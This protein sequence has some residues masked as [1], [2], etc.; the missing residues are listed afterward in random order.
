MTPMMK[1]VDDYLRLRRSLGH[2]LLK[3]ETHLRDF[4]SFMEKH[5]QEHITTAAV[6]RWATQPKGVQPSHWAARLRDVRIFAAHLAATDDPS[7]EIPPSDLLPYRPERKQ[8]HIYTEEEIQNLLAATDRLYTTTGLRSMTYVTLLGLLVVTG[9]RVSEALGLNRD[10]VDWEEAVLT[11]SSTKFNKTRLVPVHP[12]TLNAL[13]R[14]GRERDSTFRH[15]R[16]PAV[17][18]S[19]AGTRLEHSN[20]SRAFYRLSRWTGLRGT[21]DR[22]GPRLHDFRHSFA[23]RTVLRWYRDGEDVDARLPLLSTFLGHGHISDTYWYLSAIPELLS[24]AADRV[25]NAGGGTHA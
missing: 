18:V 25:E 7:T 3:T 4:V 21:T 16:T 15:P 5:H 9:L 2:K 24:L 6:V 8:P 12:T 14:Y 1:A 11:I 10:E 13:R 20:V 19:E 23:V 22:H 17:F